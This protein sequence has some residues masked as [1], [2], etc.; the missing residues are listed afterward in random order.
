MKMNIFE[1]LDNESL[2]KLLAGVDAI[3]ANESMEESERSLHELHQHQIELEIQN[4]NLKETQAQ[5]EASREQYVDLFDHA[6][7]GILSLDTAG[8]IKQVNLTA[9]RMLGVSRE[10]LSGF[11]LTSYIGDSH[12]LRLQYFLR[13]LY[14]TNKPISYDFKYLADNKSNHYRLLSSD[15]NDSP[16]YRLA[17]IDISWH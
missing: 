11:S 9:C 17:L 16:E 15:K 2:N 10:K 13:N 6:P 4:Q 1:N 14:K 5:L 8:I 12:N 7:V 3:L